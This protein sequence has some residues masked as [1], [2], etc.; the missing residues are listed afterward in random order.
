MCWFAFRLISQLLF[1]NFS[2]VYCEEKHQ[3]S[4][5]AL[6]KIL[7]WTTWKIFVRDAFSSILKD[8]LIS[9]ISTQDASLWWERPS[10]K[11]APTRDPPFIFPNSVFWIF[12]LFFSLFSLLLCVCFSMDSG[13]GNWVL[14]SLYSFGN[15]PSSFEVC[16]DVF[17]LTCFMLH[18][19]AWSKGVYFLRSIF[20]L[21]SFCFVNGHDK[22]WWLC[23]CYLQ[24][25]FHFHFILLYSP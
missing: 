4:C 25:C 11:F 10:R 12:S 1:T 18:L 16:H 15:L 22:T 3:N 23:M 8:F 6:V 14:F 17:D 21:L 2:N 9:K 19:F 24:K 13:T 5:M 20:S 7:V